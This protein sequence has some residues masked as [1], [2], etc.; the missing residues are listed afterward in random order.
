MEP[1]GE[2]EQILNLIP[3]A[4]EKTQ[5]A[6]KRSAGDATLVVSVPK[7]R[8][9]SSGHG[10]FKFSHSGPKSPLKAYKEELHEERTTNVS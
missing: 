10:P 4:R 2:R 6:N 9:S 8:R 5:K 1:R 3:L 7:H